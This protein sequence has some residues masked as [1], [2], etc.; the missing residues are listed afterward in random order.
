MI[1][2]AQGQSFWDTGC[3]VVAAADF[4]APS[5]LAT[6]LAHCHALEASAPAD[7]MH[8]LE[9][10]GQTLQRIEN[11]VAHHPPLAALLQ[12][13]PLCN[14]VAQLFGEPALLHKDKINY[15]KPGPYAFAAHQDVAAGWERYGQSL[16][17]SALIALDAIHAHNGPLEVVRGAWLGRRLS[18][19]G[20]GLD[21]ATC[22]ALHWEP[23]HMAPGDVF[24]FHS[25]VPHRSGP[26]TTGVARR[27]CYCTYSKVS[28]GD[29][30]ARYF[31]D[32]RR[33]FP[34]H[35]E[36]LVGTHYTYRI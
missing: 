18:P 8:Y 17:V 11:F 33:E 32:K 29:W 24:F 10:D 6:L 9:E 22:A 20:C 3:L 2:P 1:S 27:A 30:R 34:P 15:K 4:W 19:P 31:A 14:A 7:C 5:D 23:V 12:A 25:Y 36:R 16:H 28:E 26:N 35:A 13:G 21:A